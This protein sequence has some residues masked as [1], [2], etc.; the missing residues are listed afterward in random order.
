MPASIN[1]E[2]ARKAAAD[3]TR[4]G[5]QCRAARASYVPVVDHGRCE[6]KSDCVDVC[7]FGV[8]RVRQIDDAD[9]QALSFFGKLKSRA[10]GK[11]TAYTPG[12][13]ACQACGLCVVSCP[14]DA[15]LLVT[16][17]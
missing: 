8:F 6:G 1:P 17:T 11:Q 10:H 5:E 3:P 4:P 13:S 2:K 16:A 15:I 12:A 9:F 7:P 14:E